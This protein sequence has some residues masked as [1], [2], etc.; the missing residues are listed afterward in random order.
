MVLILRK[1]MK[2]FPYPQITHPTFTIPAPKSKTFK[3]PCKHRLKTSNI[4]AISILML[5]TIFLCHH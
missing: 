4:R 3:M 5:N 1:M 2:F